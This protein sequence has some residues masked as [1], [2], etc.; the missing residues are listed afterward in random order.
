MY[1]SRIPK[2]TIGSHPLTETQR[3]FHSISILGLTCTIMCTWMGILS[4]VVGRDLQSGAYQTLTLAKYQPF[5]PDKRW[6][7][8]HRMALPRNLDPHYPGRGF[9]RRNGIHVT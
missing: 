3:T 8:W 1:E 6:Q 9:P 7:S 2:Q 4:Y 5:L